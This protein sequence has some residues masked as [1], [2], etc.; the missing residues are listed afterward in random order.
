MKPRMNVYLTTAKRVLMYA[1]PVIVSLFEQN[2]DSEVYLYL[3]SEDLQEDDI[4]QEQKVAEKYDGHIIILH[5]DEEMA[6][7]KVASVSD[8][9]PLGTLGCYWMFHE[10]LPREIDRILVLES[11]AIVTGSL[12]EFYD[13]DLTGFYAACP[14][15]E[16]KPL[17]HRKL[18]EQLG[19]DTLTFVVSLYDVQAIQKDFTLDQILEVDRYVVKEYGH[20]QQELTFG[21]LFKDR[22]KFLPAPDLCVEENTQSMKAMGYDYLTACEKTCRVLH[23]S[24][25]RHKEKPWNPVCLMPGYNKWWYYARRSPYYQRYFEAQ[26]ESY[27]R[28]EKE[29]EALKKNITYKNVLL[30]V[31]AVYMALIMAAGIVCMN[32]ALIQP[33]VWVLVS[34]GALLPAVAVAVLFRRISIWLTGRKGG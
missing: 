26:W 7:G 6:K 28:K 8:H 2:A 9:W 16:H 15:A 12:R 22:I 25:T 23:F 19:G 11:D 24:S 3:V 14:D 10:L 34:A 5:F 29:I 21:L 27:E 20:S 13:T 1:Y 4:Q 31:L 18:M 30:M 33:I 17:S 32:M